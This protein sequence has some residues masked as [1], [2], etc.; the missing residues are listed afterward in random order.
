MPIVRVW[1]GSE[2]V[3]KDTKTDF[4]YWDGAS[5][6]EP[7]DVRAWNGV[8][9]ESVFGGTPG[10]GIELRTISQDTALSSTSVDV[11]IPASVEEGDLMVLAV[12]Q[13]SFDGGGALFNSITGWAKQGEQRAGGPGGA[14]FTLGI[15]TRVAQSGDSGGTVTSTSINSAHYAGQL[16]VYSG[17]DQTTPLDTSTVFDF[18]SASITASAPAATVATE[19]AMIIPIYGIPTQTGTTLTGDDWTGPSGFG[20]ELVTCPDSGSGNRPCIALYDA[21]T[22]GTGSQGPFSATITQSRQWALVTVVLRPAA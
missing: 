19:D 7:T 20:N 15:F 9:W 3:D 12:G 21:I 16:R 13:N 4:S 11:G 6:T 2:W 17:V 22:P 14:S 10:E 5:W 1:N 18:N 8:A